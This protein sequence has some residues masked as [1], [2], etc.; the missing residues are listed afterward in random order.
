MALCRLDVAVIHVV[1]QDALLK[2]LCPEEAVE[3]SWNP[4]H[5]ASVLHTAVVL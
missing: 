1:V 4:V 5:F 3:G 2:M